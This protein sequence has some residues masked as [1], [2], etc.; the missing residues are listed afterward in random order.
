LKVDRIEASKT[1]GEALLKRVMDLEK[2][3]GEKET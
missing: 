1:G 3:L 2:K